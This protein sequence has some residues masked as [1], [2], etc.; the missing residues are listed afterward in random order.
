MAKKKQ[1]T[2]PSGF[3]DMDLMTFSVIFTLMPN[4][5][6]ELQISTI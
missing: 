4:L 1:N 2:I 6:K 3:D 5:A